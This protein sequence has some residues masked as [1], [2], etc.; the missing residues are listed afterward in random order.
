MANIGVDVETGGFSSSHH[1]L[2]SIGMAWQEA[3]GGYSSVTLRVRPALGLEITQGAI[4]VN[5][6]TPE[7]W[8]TAMDERAALRWATDKIAEVSSGSDPVFIA[9]NATF[10]KK[11]V[12]AA[13]E[14]TGVVSPLSDP[15]KW[16]C[17]M[18]L[19]GPLVKTGEVTGRGLKHLAYAS[20]HWSEAQES[21][22]HHDAEE[23][24]LAALV[25]YNWI[26]AQTVQRP[27]R[28]VHA[29]DFSG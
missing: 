9:H 27:V 11:M 18:K 25:G 20:G 28:R 21:E 17:T 14:R 6:Y 4:D 3:D 5:G 15:Q 1:A 10:D 19:A 23:D 12:L 26:L 8:A 16:V 13:L 2:L 24:A 22:V 29:S 7:K